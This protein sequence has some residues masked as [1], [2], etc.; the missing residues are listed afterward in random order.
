MLTWKSQLLKIKNYLLHYFEA[1]QLST[2][3]LFPQGTCIPSPLI[4]K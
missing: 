2:K 4:G 3:L 1:I